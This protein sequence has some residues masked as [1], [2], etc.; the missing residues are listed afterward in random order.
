M[1]LMTEYLLMAPFLHSYREEK[2][3]IKCDVSE[4]SEKTLSC[5]FP[6]TT[7]KHA[8][9]TKTHTCSVTTALNLVCVLV[10]DLLTPL[11][12]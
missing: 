10:C 11:S 3:K 7:F 5:Q 9:E 1:A 4:T 2:T 12:P 6:L 8:S